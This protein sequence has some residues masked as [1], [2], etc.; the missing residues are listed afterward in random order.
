MKT[1][2][3]IGNGFDRHHEINCSYADFHAW[4]LE[5]HPSF[6]FDM[7]EVYGWCDGDWWSN[8]EINLGEIDVMEYAQRIAF[9][10]PVDLASDHCDSMWNDAQIAVEN[11]MSELYQSLQNYFEEWVAQL[12]KPNQETRIFID[13]HD[14]VFL[15]FNYT[16]T[17][18]DLYGIQ[19]D[20]ILHIHGEAGR[21][22]KLVIGHGLTEDELRAKYPTPHDLYH[23][24]KLDEETA[25]SFD[26]HDEWA[27]NEVFH[28]VASRRKPV[29]TII[30]QNESFFDGLTCVSK[31]CVY[32]LS[33]SDV[34][35]PYMIKI[36]ESAPNA[37]W[38][39]SCFCESDRIKVRAFAAKHGV[40][41]YS[42]VRLSELYDPNQ[43]S[44]SF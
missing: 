11:Q 43:L 9:E 23:Q 39:I 22:D 26:I 20:R 16:R 30:K 4:L 33:F 32:G 18:E 44:M 6:F 12:K 27:W 37:H 1:L 29:E 35:I 40:K 5:H 2:Y 15:N 41:D 13:Q 10:N 7:D 14:A 38:E 42:I 36:K 28:Q 24:G 8:F 3:V 17:L 19:S 25:S 31:V 34:D 21:N